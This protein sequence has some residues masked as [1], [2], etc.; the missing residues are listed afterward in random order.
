MRRI[1]KTLAANV[2][3][4]MVAVG[5]LVASAVTSMSEGPAV[6]D[7][8][9]KLSLF[10]GAV[11]DTTSDGL[12]GLAG[13]VTMPLAHTLGL[14]LDAG[15]A[16]V[17]DGN[18]GSGGAHLFWRDPTIGLF[19]IYAGYSHLD[20]SGTDVGFGRTGLEA[21]YFTRSLTLDLAGG[22]KFGD[23]EQGYGRA[24]LQFY[25]TDNLMLRGGWLYEGG[26]FGTLGIEYQ[27]ASG[28]GTG[29]A[30]FADTNLGN[31][32]SYS[33]VA[34]VRVM[35]G[36]DMT[37]K[38]R[39]RRQ[40]PESYTAVDMQSAQKAA[41]QGSCPSFQPASKL[42]SSASAAP[43]Y[44]PKIGFAL[45]RAVT[46]ASPCGSNVRICQCQQAGYSPSNPGPAA[47]GCAAAYAAC[48]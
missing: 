6:S 35:F 25:P 40:D 15:Y 33:V 3:S 26:N 8:N 37:L 45:P 17:G 11:N 12:G 7:I 34:G 19:G 21:Q 27:F 10:G 13:S 16:R 9:A 5:V 23:I 41:T 18:F 48:A 32:D 31:S 29:V 1:S 24:R 22:V 28:G 2:V 20:L 36:Q 30:L 4:A 14:Q 46:L 39:H 42:C 43:R 38:D 47:C 44:L